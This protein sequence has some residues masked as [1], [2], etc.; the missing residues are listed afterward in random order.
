MLFVVYY[1]SRPVP[2]VTYVTDYC[3]GVGH[4][5]DGAQREIEVALFLMRYDD[6]ND[7]PQVLTRK[8]VEAKKRGVDVV[9]FLDD[10]SYNEGAITFLRENNV[11]VVVISSRLLHA[12]VVKADDCFVV[13]SHNWTWNAMHRNI[14][15]SIIVCNSSV[16]DAFF[17]GLK[18]IGG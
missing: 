7:C 6:R 12:K 17:S 18:S 10:D 13:G 5:I 8:L 9:V 2:T 3:R 14:E 1:L 4:L 15:A 11:P 16:I